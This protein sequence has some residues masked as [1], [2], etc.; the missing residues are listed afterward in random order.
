M[1]S[2]RNKFP[3]SVGDGLG[4]LDCLNRLD[5]ENLGIQ[6]CNSAVRIDVYAQRVVVASLCLN[7]ES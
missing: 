1:P 5:P 7:F 6:I 2:P 4:N 3:L